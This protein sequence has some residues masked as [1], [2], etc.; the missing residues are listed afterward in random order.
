MTFTSS[1]LFGLAMI[2]IVKV[3]VFSHTLNLVYL[4]TQAAM[5]ESTVKATEPVTVSVTLPVTVP[6][7]VPAGTSF[8]DASVEFCQKNGLPL[9]NAENLSRALQLKWEETKLVQ[10]QKVK[11]CV[12]WK[13]GYNVIPLNSWGTL[14]QNLRKDWIELDCDGLVPGRLQTYCTVSLTPNLAQGP[15]PLVTLP[16]FIGE[17]KVELSLFEGDLLEPTVRRFCEK[18]GIDQ[19]ANAL[20]LEQALTQ[21]LAKLPIDLPPQEVRGTYLFSVPV[22]INGTVVRLKVHEG[23]RMNALISGF[24][25][26][27]CN[28]SVC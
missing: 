18:H 25:G 27:L 2:T 14:P 9:E 26:K 3:R 19:A 13:R 12:E 23:D 7:Q 21:E 10:E 15:E 28:L 17:N 6:F 1:L 16:V 4:K 11:Q 20:P 8:I 22:S 24:C 5:L